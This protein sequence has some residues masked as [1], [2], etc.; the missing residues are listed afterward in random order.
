MEC[1]SGN[2]NPWESFVALLFTF[3]KTAL[4]PFIEDSLWDMILL[5]RFGLAIKDTFADYI[6]IKG[7]IYLFGKVIFWAFEEIFT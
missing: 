1:V 6:I 4:N 3:E 5:G 2:L 7:P